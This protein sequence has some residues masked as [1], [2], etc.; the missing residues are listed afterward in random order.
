MICQTKPKG[1]ITQ[2]KIALHEY[3]LM[4]TTLSKIKTPKCGAIRLI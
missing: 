1:A 2:M 3:I 4:V